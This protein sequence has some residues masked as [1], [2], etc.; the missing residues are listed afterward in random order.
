MSTSQHDFYGDA[1]YF[2]I[3]DMPSG[4][5]TYDYDKFYVRQFAAE[6]LPLLH[7]GMNTRVRAHEHVIRAVQMA[8][9]ADIS[10]L[11]DGDLCYVMAWIRRQSFPETPL[12]AKY[13]CT[14]MLFQDDVGNIYHKIT[15]KEADLKGYVL[16]ACGRENVNLIKS[17]AINI[18][19]LEDESLQVVNHPDIDFARVITLADFHEMVDEKPW[20]RYKLD[21]ARWVR[22]GKT[23]K[24][25]LM[26]LDSQP[27]F[28]LWEAIEKIK[29]KH[30]HGITEEIQLRCSDCNNVKQHESTPCLLKFFADNSDK[31][32]YNMTYNLMAQ[33]G[34]SPNLKMPAQMLM[35][36]H[37]T[38][39]DDRRK[40]DQAAKERAAQHRKGFR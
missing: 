19:T 38:L 11:T 6:E 4:G 39:V 37:S 13:V 32:V 35:Y 8:C 29:E 27:D 10:Q 21:L 16:K 23:L 9:S 26:F 33:F 36:H 25:K 2:D 15:R 24:A 22:K 40:S 5:K 12:Q 14:N 3:G 18:H 20:L 28:K 31:D 17:T 34:A 7:Y 30:F 1:R